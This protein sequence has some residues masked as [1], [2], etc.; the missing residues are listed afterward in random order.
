MAKILIAEDEPDIR[1]LVAFML[2]FAGYEVVAASNGEEAVQTAT[3]EIPDL[4]PDGCAHASH[5]RL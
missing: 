2:R 1:E 3:R 4:D 5:D